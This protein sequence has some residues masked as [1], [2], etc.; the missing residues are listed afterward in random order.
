[1]ATGLY[2]LALER[3]QCSQDECVMEKSLY[4]IQKN[5]SPASNGLNIKHESESWPALSPPLGRLL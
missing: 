2:E 4:Y 5:Y 3:V 1:M